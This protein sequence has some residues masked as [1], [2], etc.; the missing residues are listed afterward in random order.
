MFVPDLADR[1]VEQSFGLFRRHLQQ[2]RQAARVEHHQRLHR[3]RTA[4]EHATECRARAE[5]RAERDRLVA[6]RVVEVLDHVCRRCKEMA[7]RDGAAP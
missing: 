2:A 3:I 1:I 6:E 4:H 7:T 5:A